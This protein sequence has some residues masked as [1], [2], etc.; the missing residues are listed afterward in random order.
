MELDVITY[1][2][3]VLAAVAGSKD[4]QCTVTPKVHMMLKHVTWQMTNIKGGLGDKMEDWVER[5]HQTGMRMRRRFRTVANPLV[6]AIAREKTNSRNAHPDVIAHLDV[7]NKR[8]KRKFVS[9]KKVDVIGTRRKR[10]RDMGRFEAMQYFEQNK[11]K[12]LT[13]SALLFSDDKGLMGGGK[14]ESTTMCVIVKT[15]F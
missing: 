10:Q 2:R 12:K 11:N 5:L 8:S 13:W 4:L 6:R 15:N 9:E 1:Q 7:T 14:A 3:Y